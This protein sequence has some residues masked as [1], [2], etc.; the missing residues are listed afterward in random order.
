MLKVPYV[1]W[2]KCIPKSLVSVSFAIMYQSIYNPSFLFRIIPALSSRCARFEFGSLPC[3]NVVN[4][5]RYISTEEHMNINDEVNFH[6]S[7]HNRHYII[8][9]INQK[10]IFVQVYIY[11]R[12]VIWFTRRMRLPKR[13]YRV[14]L[15]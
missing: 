7:S 14:L 1:E 8:Y 10:V 5:L 11:C 15:W 12:I 2:W 13:N 9:M 4:R 6:W 3:E